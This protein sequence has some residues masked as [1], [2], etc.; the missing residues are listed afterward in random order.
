M[1]LRPIRTNFTDSQKAEIFAR[2]RATCCFSGKSL[3]ILDYQ[4]TPLYDIDWVD[5]VIPCSRG[6]RSEID[7]GV[8]AS[9]FFNSKKRD[10]SADNVYF[11]EEGKP[12]A[13]Y[14]YFYG[15]L[16]EQLISQLKRFSVLDVSDWW[17]NR[18][19]FNVIL[20]LRYLAEKQRF[21]LTP[22]RSDEYWF[23]AG[24]KRLKTFRSLV[25]ISALPSIEERG[26]ALI[27]EDPST[28]Q[29]LA[30]MDKHSEKEFL[31]HAYA[32]YP[33]FCLNYDLA[34]SFWEADSVGEMR[35][36]LQRAEQSD[37]SPLLYQ[38][39]CSHYQADAG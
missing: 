14:F 12:T 3:W 10:N 6:G 25:S 36:V 31:E 26:L 2:D 35:H 8:C 38:A 30:F 15:A 21:S 16:S 33:Q 1:G 34:E 39:I 27:P 29:L 20:G 28:R 5:H 24:W 9:S 4:L 23:R 11:F 22:K 32:I 19:L 18:S 17:F 7:N 13:N 37:C